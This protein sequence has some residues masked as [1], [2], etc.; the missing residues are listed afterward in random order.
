M[1]EGRG[2]KLI[3]AAVTSV[4]VMMVFPG[5]SIKAKSRQFSGFG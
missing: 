3:A 1:E 2:V 5:T 4:D